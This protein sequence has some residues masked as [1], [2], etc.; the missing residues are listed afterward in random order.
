M[1]RLDIII[2]F[3]SNDIRFEVTVD[4]VFL[5]VPLSMSFFYK[6]SVQLRDVF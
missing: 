4:A 5:L 1:I 2:S 3:F 6:A